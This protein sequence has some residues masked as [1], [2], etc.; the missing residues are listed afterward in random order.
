M[1]PWG[2]GSSRLMARERGKN[3]RVNQRGEALLSL[4]ELAKLG[5]ASR[6]RLLWI[7]SISQA[8][9]IYRKLHPIHAAPAEHKL[10]VFR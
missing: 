10:R 1:R 3:G 4:R 5:I 8:D 2:S 6:C 7:L 9:P